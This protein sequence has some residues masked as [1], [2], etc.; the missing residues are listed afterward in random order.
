MPL[1]TA[2]LTTSSRPKR[3]SRSKRRRVG[4]VPERAARLLVQR[5][6]VREPE[7]RAAVAARAGVVERRLVVEHGVVR[8]VDV[9]RQ[10]LGELA[11]VVLADVER[12]APDPRPV[13]DPVRHV[14]LGQRDP[15][16]DRP[17]A[18]AVVVAD[19]V[20]HEPLARV[21]ADA[22]VPLLPLDLVVAAREARPLRLDELQRLEAGPR[23]VG[24]AGDRPVDRPHPGVGHVDDARAVIAAHRHRDREALDRPVVG[25]LLPGPLEERERAQEARARRHAGRQLDLA[26]RPD[27]E[28]DVV[29]VRDPAR[30]DRVAPRLVRADRFVC[31]PVLR[32]VD[33]RL[34]AAL[35]RQRQH[36]RGV[37]TEIDDGLERAVGLA[38]RRRSRTPRA[39]TAGRATRRAGPPCA[40]P[41]T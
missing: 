40:A 21:E 10:R 19:V 8:D 26:G 25:V 29:G 23:R 14:D 37:G 35:E 18:A 3:A 11:E 17:H 1:T 28:V 38:A 6:R 7:R 39:R 13:R 4:P 32:V 24:A 41:S 33:R 22:E 5:D 9:A 16:D 34:H 27:V 31:G 20:Q 12:R 15:A 30:G 2:L 36:S